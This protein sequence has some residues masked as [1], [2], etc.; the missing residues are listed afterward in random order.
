[1]WNIFYVRGV[2]HPV[3]PQGP[4][5]QQPVLFENMQIPRV[6]FKAR[7]ALSFFE[8]AAILRFMRFLSRPPASLTSFGFWFEGVA[9]G[10]SL[11]TETQNHGLCTISTIC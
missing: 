3:V 8:V 1:M 6:F 9:H 4:Q 2:A 5:P 7:K 11:L 10:C